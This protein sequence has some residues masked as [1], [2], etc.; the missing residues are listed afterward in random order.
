MITEK[1]K[2]EILEQEQLEK[3]LFEI[4]LQN[5]K[6]RQCRIVS[7]KNLSRS[8][9]WSRKLMFIEKEKIHK[10]WLDFFTNDI[11]NELENIEKQIGDNYF[12]SKENILRFM[13]LDLNKVKYIIVG[14][15]PYPSS[16]IENNQVIPE[17][18]GRSFEVSSVK[19]WNKNLNNHL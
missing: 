1:E 12:P 11:E 18:T 8:R 6:A 3:E 9:I 19:S 5:K 17:A 7:S 10:S 16:Y 2:L 14:M 13:Q 4:E 15:E